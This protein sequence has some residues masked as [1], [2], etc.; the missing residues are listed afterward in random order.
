MYKVMIVDDEHIIRQGIVS[1]IDWNELGCEVVQEAADGN[2]AYAYLKEHQVD[3][4]VCDIRMP[5]KS[6]LELAEVIQEEEMPV[7]TILLTAYA[8]FEYARQAMRY[9]IRDY[10][11]KTDYIESLPVVTKKLI[12][13]IEEERKQKTELDHAM[14]K[15]DDSMVLLQKKLVTDLINGAVRGTKEMQEQASWCDFPMEPFYLVNFIF[16]TDSI[17]KMEEARREKTLKAVR[18]FIDLS[19]SDYH[20]LTVLISDVDFV[21]LVFS[22]KDGENQKKTFSQNLRNALVKLEEALKDTLDIEVNICLSRNWEQIYEIGSLYENVHNA[23]LRTGFFG[24]RGGVQ[25]EMEENRDEP[26]QLNSLV[27]QVTE[28]IEL[29]FYAEAQE[30][31]EACSRE[32]MTE[33]YSLKSIKS[34]AIDI[35]LECHRQIEKNNGP[36]S[37]SCEYSLPEYYEIS[38][39][40]NVE[41]LRNMLKEAVNVTAIMEKKNKEEFSPLVREC[42]TYIRDHYYERINIGIIA[43]RLCV[44]K[45][46][47][48]TVFK[49]ETGTSIVEMITRYRLDKA[50][51]MMRQTRYK[52][53]EISEKVGFDDP[54]YFTNV[55]TK[56]MGLS[57]SA[58][59]SSKQK[60]EDYG[61]KNDTL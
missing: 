18:N 9:G 36:L 58:Y 37:G 30:G 59:R 45:S 11:V 60:G 10:I 49:K 31:L 32:I 23:N 1:L 4:L 54:A 55:F 42:V 13:E 53:F 29:G 56:Y 46:Y 21:T 43:D 17:W 12:A 52:L 19:L 20:V 50:V 16:S 3:I 47:L 27:K 28:K 57:P 51:E 7:R 41:Q 40:R 22:G 24:R 2:T 48:G 25:D 14:E 8:D 6:G 34:K 38:G 61:K 5:G 35:C 33:R 26:N 39:C 15:L 44:N